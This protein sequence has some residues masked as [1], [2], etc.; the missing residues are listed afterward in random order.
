MSVTNSRCLRLLGASCGV[1]VVLCGGCKTTDMA[2]EDPFFEKWQSVKEQSRLADVKFSEENQLPEVYADDDQVLTPLS[3]SEE[4]DQRLPTT[5]VKDLSLSEKTE[6]AVVLRTLAEAG[7]QNILIGE[8]VTQLVEVHFADVP[9]NE[10]FKSIL[11]TAG[12][13]YEWEGDIIRVMSLADMQKQLE[14]QR[15]KQQSQALQAATRQVE[16]MHVRMVR[17]KFSNAEKIAAL[18]GEILEGRSLAAGPRASV[19]VD[20]DSNTIVVH[21][22]KSEL[23]KISHLIARLDRPKPQVL[24]ESKIVETNR[25]TARELGVQW[26]GGVQSI[27]GN[28]VHRVTA[29][30]LGFSSDTVPAAFAVGVGVIWG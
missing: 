28:R 5:I 23:D 11:S 22:I 19:S 2:M 16:P 20:V 6:V 13:S 4:A 25:S 8:G 27:S 24:I 21:A 18:V 30:G 3:P 9:W 14:I 7:S 29:R 12:L 1:L 15:I 26:G 17:I 10:A